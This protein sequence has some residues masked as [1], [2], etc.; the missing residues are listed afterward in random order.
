MPDISIEECIRK[1]TFLEKSLG[2]KTQYQTLDPF[3]LYSKDIIGIQ[4]AGKI[5]ANFI[6]LSDY[7]FVI[8]INKLE[9]NTGGYIKLKHGKKQVFIAKR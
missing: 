4:N 2:M 3:P 1:V 9:K 7:I 8:S 5:I 6:G